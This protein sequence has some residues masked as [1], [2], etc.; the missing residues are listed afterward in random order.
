MSLRW[1]LSVSR[2]KVGRARSLK[3][4]DS[5]ATQAI[6]FSDTSLFASLLDK[7][8]DE[9]GSDLSLRLLISSKQLN[10]LNNP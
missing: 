5:P 4:D 10:E 2:I 6:L 1:V 7:N 9:L 3:Q 8:L